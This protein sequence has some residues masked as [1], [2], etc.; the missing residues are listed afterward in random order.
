MPHPT[1]HRRHH[2]ASQ[3]PQSRLAAPADFEQRT[4]AETTGHSG[5]PEAR[6]EPPKLAPLPPVTA[7]PHSARQWCPRVIKQSLTT[8][9]LSLTPGS[10][11]APLCAA[12]IRSHPQEPAAAMRAA[13]LMGKDDRE[14]D[15]VLWHC[16]AL[17]F[18][19]FLFWGAYF[20]QDDA[21]VSVMR[22]SLICLLL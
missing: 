1:R 4:E 2:P 15:S 18:L 3:W 8:T 21:E 17:L 19:A 9:P 12:A 5:Q 6:S 10:S 13:A 16:I 7:A 14:R 20:F 11:R 22:K